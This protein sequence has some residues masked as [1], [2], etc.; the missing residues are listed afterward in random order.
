MP[1]GGNTP[2]PT[3]RFAQQRVFVGCLVQV[4]Q[5]VTFLQRLHD[6]VHQPGDDQDFRSRH[7]LLHRETRDLPAGG[8]VNVGFDSLR[9]A[10]GFGPQQSA[11]KN[12]QRSRVDQRARSIFPGHAT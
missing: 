7:L 8:N 5:R 11:A 2:N 1:V 6:A 10:C 3:R 4:M 9:R 12:S